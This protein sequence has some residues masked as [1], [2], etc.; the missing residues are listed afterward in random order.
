MTLNKNT[1]RSF[2]LKKRLN[3]SLNLAPNT[4]YNPGSEKLPRIE[5]P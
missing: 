2:D 5:S 4:A 3:S 1:N